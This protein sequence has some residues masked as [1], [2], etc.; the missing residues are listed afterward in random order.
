MSDFEQGKPPVKG[1][2]YFFTLKIGGIALFVFIFL[3]ALSSFFNKDYVP[4][5]TDFV[6][7]SLAYLFGAITSQTVSKH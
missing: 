5:W 2:G 6:K 7:L 3:L 1:S 4:M